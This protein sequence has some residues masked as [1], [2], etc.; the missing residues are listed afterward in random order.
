[1]LIGPLGF[2]PKQVDQIWS[3]MDKEKHISG[4]VFNSKRYELL[5]DR[6]KFILQKKVKSR[7]ANIFHL[8]KKA[9]VYH[10]PEGELCLL[11]Q[12]YPIDIDPNSHK[13]YLDADKLPDQLV[14][15]KWVEGDVF[16]PL[17]LSTGRQ[18]ISDF[19]INNKVNRTQ[20]QKTYVLTASDQIAWLAPHRIAEPFKLSTSTKNV[21]LLEWKP[22]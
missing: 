17:G 4:K 6:D 19:L 12:P 14:W 3:L 7:K 2:H 21:L 15:R 13:A 18:K 10:L 16:H 11:E 22:N 8:P 5:V 9:A 1:H 20:K